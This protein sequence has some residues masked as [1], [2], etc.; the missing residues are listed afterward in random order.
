VDSAPAGRGAA[1]GKRKVAG[2]AG[3]RAG[4]RSCRAMH[5]V[6]RAEVVPLAE[7]QRVRAPSRDGEP[8]VRGLGSHSQGF[9]RGER[10]L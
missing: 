2:L 8:G 1:G 4:C 6:G 9:G 7:L 3:L 5:A 10:Q